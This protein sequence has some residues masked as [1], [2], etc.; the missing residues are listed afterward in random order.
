M[1]IGTHLLLYSRDPEADRAFFRDV[2][3]FSH[4][5]VGG[6]WLIFALPPAEVGVHPAEKNLTQT[7]AGHDLA[8]GTLYLLCSPL[9]ATLDD[10]AAKGVD[11]TEPMEAQWGIATS[12]QLPGGASLGLYEPK[13][14]LAVKTI[15]T[16]LSQEETNV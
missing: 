12:I 5:D 9:K 13:H 15:G 3:G 10:L 11:H 7:H 4:V 8:T 14:A 6:G 16:S 1:I 2:L